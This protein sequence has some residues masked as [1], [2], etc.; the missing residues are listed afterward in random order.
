VGKRIVVCRRPGRA[1]GPGSE[2]HRRLPPKVEQ[3]DVDAGVA[4]RSVFRRQDVNRLDETTV[5]HEPIRVERRVSTRNRLLDELLQP[6]RVRHLPPTT[7]REMFRPLSTRPLH[8]T[9]PIRC[10]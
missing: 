9:P 8:G 1:A 10:H 4:V 5:A 6:H 7:I 3:T 2:G